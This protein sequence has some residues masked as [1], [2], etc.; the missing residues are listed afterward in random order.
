MCPSHPNISEKENA[1]ILA[2]QMN[3]NTVAVQCRDLLNQVKSLSYIVDDASKLEDVRKCL[4]HCVGI[5]EKSAPKASNG[6]LLERPSTK[7]SQPKM[8]Q[9]TRKPLILH[10]PQA[11]RKGKYTGRVGK[12]ANNLKRGWHVDPLN[13]TSSKNSKGAKVEVELEVVA[14][15]CPEFNHPDLAPNKH[16]RIPVGAAVTQ[17]NGTSRVSSAFK[18]SMKD[19]DLK[20]VSDNQSRSPAVKQDKSNPSAVGTSDMKSVTP[21]KHKPPSYTVIQDDSCPFGHK[22]PVANGNTKRNTAENHKVQVHVKQ[23]Q[24]TTAKD[25]KQEP[26]KKV[27]RIQD[28]AIFLSET[29]PSPTVWISHQNASGHKQ[30]TLYSSS[31]SNILSST[32]WLTDSEVEDG[33]EDPSIVSDLVTPAASEFVQIINT[34]SHWVCLSAISCPTGEVKVYDSLYGSPARK[35]VEHACRLLHYK[36]NIV[37]IRN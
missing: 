31:K 7:S 27:P 16:L 9:S 14:E 23:K 37:K 30:I 11:K 32:G 35:T 26:K 17:D 4:Q 18:S 2:N 8:K 19:E 33:L 29:S 21:V 5:M 10:L 13:A 6:F 22:L 36:G 3:N 34:G 24:T 20:P 1:S 28:S 15:S 25:A 12:A